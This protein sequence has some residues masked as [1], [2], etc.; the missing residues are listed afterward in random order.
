ML[1][2]W[3]VLVAAS[4]PLCAQDADVTK[5]LQDIRARSVPRDPKVEVR[6]SL[7][8]VTKRL[9][10]TTD[11]VQR[12]NLYRNISGMELSLGDPEA[13]I[14]AARSARD[15]Q[16]GNA[17]AAL[18]LARVLAY[19]GHTAEVA[20]MIGVDTGDSAALIRKAKELA[21]AGSDLPLAAFCA[22]LAHKLLP[23]DAGVTDALGQIY[24][25]EGF[26]GQ[27]A[28][29]FLQ[30]I[31]QAPQVSTYHYHF[32]LA[33]LQTGLTADARSELQSALECHPADDE[34]VAIQAALARLDPP[35]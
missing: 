24:M 27:A 26:G 4:M 8:D 10:E 30:A 9:E 14:A 20:A 6:Q 22:D 1:A 15:L 31:A 16:P 25:T 33:R 32:A 7:A 28:I 34:R 19:T 29:V 3:L 12:A 2:R 35:K 17:V 21:Q 23:E 18:G 5:Y 11:P 13:A